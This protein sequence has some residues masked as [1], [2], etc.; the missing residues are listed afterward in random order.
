MLANEALLARFLGEYLNAPAIL[1]G[2]SMGGTIALGVAAR[3]PHRLSALVLVNPWLATFDPP[4]SG[5]RAAA[6]AYRVPSKLK[7]V[8]LARR[9]STD[10]ESMTRQYF[11]LSCAEPDR[12]PREVATA[13]HAAMTAQLAAEEPNLGFR[14][15][16]ESLVAAIGEPERYRALATEVR[17]PTLLAHGTADRLV[18]QAAFQSLHRVRPDWR[19][20]SLPGVGHAPH[21]EEP[22]WLAHLIDSWLL[23]AAPNTVR[24]A[25]QPRPFP[26]RPGTDAVLAVNGSA[27]VRALP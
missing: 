8:L 20:L 19:R 1:V 4:A 13:V 22:G 3:V 6:A 12:V 25:H 10:P 27:L 14:Q 5:D 16:A 23:D 18:P 15:A 2:A 11:R 7:A 21:L 17:V 26:A 24:P 9:D